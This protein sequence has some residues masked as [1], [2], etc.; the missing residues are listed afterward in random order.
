[1]KP[2]TK[3]LLVLAG[4]VVAFIVAWVAVLIRIALTRGPDAQSM[5]GM[6][7]AG[8][9][10]LFLFVFAIAAVPATAAAFLFLRHYRAFRVVVATIAL[11]IAAT[12][13][14]A[15]AGYAFARTSDWGG[16][17]PIR[18]ILAAVFVVPFA[19]AALLLPRGASRRA[20]LTAAAI[21]IAVGG[22]GAFVWFTPL[23]R[24]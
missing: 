10:F 21:E 19:V 5:G 7:A 17:A 13:I 12:G 9:A 23:F 1:M 22:Y 6:Y 15:V 16:L 14:G 2:L 3:I 11:V 4:Y 8:D 24:H 18:I 20:L